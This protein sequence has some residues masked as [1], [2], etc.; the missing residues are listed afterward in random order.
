MASVRAASPVFLPPRN[1]LEVFDGLECYM[2]FDAKGKHLLVTFKEVAR[3][4]NGS[5]KRIYTV[6]TVNA[7]NGVCP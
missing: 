7:G 6:I 3:V 4:H 2:A 1:A 5:L